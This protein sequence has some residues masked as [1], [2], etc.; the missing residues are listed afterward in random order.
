MLALI[1]TI[2]VHAVRVYHEV[3]FLAFTME[4]IK[5]LK[6]ILMMNIVVSC[7]MGNLQHNRFIRAVC[8]NIRS[9]LHR[10]F[11]HIIEDS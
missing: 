2:S 1:A 5:E 8:R 6:S 3:E 9:V 4:C 11:I 7:A 10:I